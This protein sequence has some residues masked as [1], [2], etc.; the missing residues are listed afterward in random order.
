MSLFGPTLDADDLAE[1]REAVE[2]TL[3][4][5]CIIHDFSTTST[6]SGASREVWT[7]R[8]VQEP[9]RLEPLAEREGRGKSAEYGSQVI[10]RPQGILN[11]KAGTVIKQNDKVHIQTGRFAGRMYRMTVEF[12]MEGS[13]WDASRRVVVEP[14]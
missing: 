4:D 2:D 10:G 14:A 6:A 13:D 7:P 1:L 3:Q 8:A 9:C 5:R 11:L 12:I